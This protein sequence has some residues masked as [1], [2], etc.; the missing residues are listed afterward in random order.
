VTSRLVMASP[1]ARRLAAEQGKDLAMITGT[2]PAGAVLAADV[3]NALSPLGPIDRVQETA[4]QTD[5]RDQSLPA[6][7]G[8]GQAANG[9][10]ELALSNIWRIMAER[11]TQ[12]WTNVPHFYLVR[13]V[14]ASRLMNLREQILKLSAEKITYTDLLVKIVAMALRQHPRLNVSWN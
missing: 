7:V 1:K 13:E 12:S 3:L 5:G 8:R 4:L 2:G 11:T 14:N 6:E 9:T 10:G